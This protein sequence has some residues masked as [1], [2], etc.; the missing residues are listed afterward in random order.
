[1]WQNDLTMKA[2]PIAENTEQL[3]GKLIIRLQGRE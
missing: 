2:A 3:K 1:M